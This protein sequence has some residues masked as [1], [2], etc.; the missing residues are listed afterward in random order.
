MAAISPNGILAWT[1]FEG[2]LKTKDYLKIIKDRLLKKA[3]QEFEDEEW[4]LQQDGD[5][6]HTS[7]A[8]IEQLE[9]WGT[10]RNFSLLP[11]PANSPDLNPI[12]NFG[13]ALKSMLLIEE[14][15][16]TLLCSR[17]K[18]RLLWKH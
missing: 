10:S 15:A 18:F 13:P 2:D 1:F 17:R 14:C 5:P 16:T 4:I 11:W 12:E 6:A 8:A 9:S 7:H 3:E